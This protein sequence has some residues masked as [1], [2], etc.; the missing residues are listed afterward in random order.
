MDYFKP[1][2]K[3]PVN[4]TRVILIAIGAV[5][6]ATMLGAIAWIVYNAVQFTDYQDPSY[7]FA[8]HYPSKWQVIKAPQAGVAVVFLSPKESALD[9]FRE[10]INV[11]VQPVPDDIASI[12]TFSQTITEQ[13]KAVFQSNIKILEDK[14]FVFS[15]RQGHRMVF[16][17]HQPDRLKAMVV[18]TIRKGQA[19]ILTYITTIRKYPQSSSKVEEVLKSFQLK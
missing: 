10:N 5:A 4:I 8:V 17:A 18:W 2:P 7:K 12:K 15:G 9:V 16:E 6:L 11:T 19:Y 14:P 3:P 13:M 1:P